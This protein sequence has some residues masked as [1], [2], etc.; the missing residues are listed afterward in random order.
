MMACDMNGRDMTFLVQWVGGLFGRRKAIGF[1]DKAFMGIGGPR[2][3]MMHEI[4]SALGRALPWY[5]GQ[6]P[7]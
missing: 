5:R 1:Y 3:A 2:I 6:F 7:E 4:Q